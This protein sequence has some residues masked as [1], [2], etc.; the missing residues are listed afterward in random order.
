MA[1][2]TYNIQIIR[3][4]FAY[5]YQRLGKIGKYINTEQ[6]VKYYINFSSGL[7]KI[8]EQVERMAAFNFVNL[9]KKARGDIIPSML[10]C[11]I[12][13]KIKHLQFLFPMF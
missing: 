10:F 1:K 12:I 13:M 5:G 6:C 3:R 8:S 2:G 9:R 11:D 4:T 7:E